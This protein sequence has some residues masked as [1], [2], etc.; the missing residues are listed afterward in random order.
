MREDRGMDLGLRDRVYIITGGSAGL[1][2]A[3]ARALVADGARVVLSARDQG[4]LSQ[5]TREL[6]VGNTGVVHAE[7]ADNAD[8]EVPGR[9]IEAARARFGRLDGALISV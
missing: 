7:Q 6:S 9:L 8:P 1:G 4:R 2:L 5:A 3:T